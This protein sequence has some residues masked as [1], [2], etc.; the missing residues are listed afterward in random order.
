MS[1]LTTSPISHIVNEITDQ[2]GPQPQWSWDLKFKLLPESNFDFTNP[3]LARTPEEKE[4]FFI[5]ISFTNIDFVMDFEKGFCAH[6]N[7]SMRVGAGMWLKV[8]SPYREFLRVYMVR[9]RRLSQGGAVDQESEPKSYVFKP[10]FK[11]NAEAYPTISETIG[12]TRTEL[13]IRDLLTLDID[14]LDPATEAIQTAACG[15]IWRNATASDVMQVVFADVCSQMEYEGEKI[16]KGQVISDRTNPGKREHISV[17]PGTPLVDL[18][19]VLQKDQGGI[20]T[21]GCSRFLFEGVW[22]F[23]PPYDTTRIDRERY[24]LTIAKIPD[25]AGTGARHTYMKDGDQLKIIAASDS[26]IQDFTQANFLTQGDGVRFAKA[27]SV[28]DDWLE[29]K[30][31]KAVAKRGKN[32]TEVRMKA[33]GQ[34]DHRTYNADRRFT[35][36][37]FEQFSKLASRRGQLLSLTWN[38]ADH[39]LLKPGMPCRVLYEE[40]DQIKELH[41]V[42]VGCH[43]AVQATESAAAIGNHITTCALFVFCNKPEKAE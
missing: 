23:Y 39:T 5:P 20:W 14:L 40:N 1:N 7:A 18:P 10:I 6:V 42:L 11:D 8:L 15:G 2:D 12:L 31:N 35:D 28:M 41:G 32:N 29:V 27:G 30:D 37:S 9:E 38:Y 16:I 19:L 3:D 22:Y 4:G 43:A 34:T 26:Q 21:T 13:D 17:I 36:N 24:T 33:P 25:V